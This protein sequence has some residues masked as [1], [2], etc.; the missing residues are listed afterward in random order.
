MVP[1]FQLHCVK[2]FFVFS[3]V[4]WR[5]LLHSSPVTSISQAYQLLPLFL[6]TSLHLHFKPLISLVCIQVQSLSSHWLCFPDVP[7]VLLPE[8]KSRSTYRSNRK[9]QTVMKTEIS[10]DFKLTNL[11]VRSGLFSRFLW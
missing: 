10:S 8:D 7:C 2:C 4:C 1:S 11:Q 6:Y 9:Q 5:L 3:G